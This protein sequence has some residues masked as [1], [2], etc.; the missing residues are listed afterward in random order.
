MAKT[1]K[2]DDA[3][4]SVYDGAIKNSVA[5]SATL[6]LEHAKTWLDGLDRRP[7]GPETDLV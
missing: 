1:T 2:S 6:A 4:L 5:P 7:V 3:G